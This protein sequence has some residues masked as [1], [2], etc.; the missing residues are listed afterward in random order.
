MI[1]EAIRNAIVTLHPLDIER[2][3]RG[4]SPL[5][6]SLSDA[7]LSA[8]ERRV[9]E[10]FVR[11]VREEFEDELRSIWLFGSRARGEKPGPESDVDVLIVIRGANL[12]THFRTVRLMDQAAEAEGANPVFFSASVYDP[13]RVEQRREIR[14]FFIQEVDR[15]KIVL[16]GEA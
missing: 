3:S 7:T 13:Q 10:R 11:L 2:C 14:S 12:E 5:M 15:D 1:S 9:L 4:Y 16:H 8:L 6:T